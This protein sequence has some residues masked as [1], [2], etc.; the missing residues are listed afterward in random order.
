MVEKLSDTQTD[1][2]VC[3]AYRRDNL[4]TPV[5]RMLYDRKAAAFQLSISLRALDYLLAKK[6]LNTRRIGA[7]VLIPHGELVRYSRQDH[8]ESV[9]SLQRCA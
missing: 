6:A 3:S 8:P 5:A 9:D 2:D 7:K 4:P 1:N